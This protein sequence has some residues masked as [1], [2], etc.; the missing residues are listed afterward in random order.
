MIGYKIRYWE[1]GYDCWGATE[2]CGG[3][4]YNN[5]TY[6]R[7]NAAEKVMEDAKKQFPDREFEIY[8]TEIV[9]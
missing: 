6:L 4:D 7:Y 9:E 2:L 8:E 3:Y 1:Y 5:I